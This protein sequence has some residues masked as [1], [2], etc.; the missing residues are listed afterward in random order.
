MDPPKKYENFGKDNDNME[1]YHLGWKG[2]NWRRWFWWFGVWRIFWN[3]TSTKKKYQV[4]DNVK[5]I[6]VEVY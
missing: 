6:W 5:E 2:T 1:K 3:L 4:Y